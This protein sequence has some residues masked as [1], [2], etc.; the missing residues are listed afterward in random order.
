MTAATIVSGPQ[1]LD[2]PA[3][4]ALWPRRVMCNAVGELVGL[5]LSGTVA[6]GVMRSIEPR[7]PLAAAT[8]ALPLTF[9]APAVLP[10]DAPRRCWSWRSRSA[11]VSS[12]ASRLRWHGVTL[13]GFAA[14]RG[15]Q[16]RTAL[17]RPLR[18]GPRGRLVPAPSGQEQSWNASQ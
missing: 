12:A 10:A 1:R 6:A 13:V 8:C 7:W 18:R 15:T 11:H 9:L 5:G 3:A 17:L 4:V 2:G 16:V 14:G